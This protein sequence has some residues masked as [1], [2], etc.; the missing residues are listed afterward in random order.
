MPLFVDGEDGLEPA[1]LWLTESG[2]PLK[3]TSR[4]KVFERA[5]ERCAAAGLDVYARPKMLR[6][7][8]ALRTLIALDRQLRLTPAERLHYEQVYG[9]VWLMSRTCSG[10]AVSR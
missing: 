9:Q 2:L 10:T 1:T 7:S 8:M 6:H 3:Y 5:S 4:R